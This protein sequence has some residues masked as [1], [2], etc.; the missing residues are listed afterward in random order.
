MVGIFLEGR[1]EKLRIRQIPKRSSFANL[2]TSTLLVFIV[3]AGLLVKAFAALYLGDA[4]TVLPGTADQVSYQALAVR[5]LDGHG[6][7]FDKAWWPATKAGEPTAH[8]SYLYVFFLAGIYKVFGIHPLTARL[9]QTI[10]VGVLQVLLTYGI[11]AR[12]FGKGA[13]LVGA[14]LNVLYLY[15]TYYSA[16]LMT[17]PFYITAILGTLYAAILIGDQKFEGH[18]DPKTIRRKNLYYALSLGLTVGAAVLLRQLFLLFLPFLYLWI[19][20][21][22]REKRT[23]SSWR[24]IL[25]SSAVIIA[26]ILPFT[27]YNY[28]RFQRFVL[29]NTNAGFAFY[30]GNHPIHG[31]RFITAREMEDYQ[32]LIPSEYS[33][34]DEAALDLALLSQGLQFVIDDPVRYLQL[35]ISRIPVYFNFWPSG[36]SGMISN[37]TRVASFGLYLPFFIVG[38]VL[39]FRNQTINGFRKLLRSPGALLL[40]FALVYTVIHVL[41]WTLVRYR[42]PVDAVLI[43]FAALA[44]KRLLLSRIPDEELVTIQ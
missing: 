30:W 3:T 2:S 20:W 31:N 42:L 12:L 25:I 36:E 7:T 32:A 13:G 15:F 8:W 35:S 9:I 11:S 26:T 17:E 38:I 1:G 28:A 22:V 19:W 24:V 16:T 39:Y 41:T 33:M 10:L 29:L 6:F 44:A 37:V 34:L 21:A 14:A 5:V 18:L 40:L 27:V 4:V 43:P 23:I